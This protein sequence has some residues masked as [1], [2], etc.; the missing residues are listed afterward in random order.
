MKGKKLL[1]TAVLALLLSLVFATTAF[2]ADA[3]LPETEP[4]ISADDS[5]VIG[6]GD[7]SEGTPPADGDDITA[8][9]DN[10][11]SSDIPEDGEADSTSDGP[12]DGEADSS[13]DVPGDGEADSSSDIPGDGDGNDSSDISEDGDDSEGL[14]PADGEEAEDKSNDASTGYE[15]HFGEDQQVTIQGGGVTP[16]ADILT[17]LGIEGEVTAASGSNDNL[18][19]FSQDENGVWM[20]NSHNAFSTEQTMTLVVNGEEVVVRVTD[21][22]VKAVI[23]NNQTEHDTSVMPFRR[24][25]TPPRSASPSRRM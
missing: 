4:V 7:D 18:F 10:N 22:N 13:S 11:D 14:P 15:I 16:L 17:A 23:G 21:E 25:A 3:D 2:A 12:G 20:F 6:D 19:T 5:S 8:D 24:Q 1:F 9:A